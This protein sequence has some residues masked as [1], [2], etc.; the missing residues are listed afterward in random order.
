MS[1]NNYIQFRKFSFIE[2]ILFFLFLIPA[3]FSYFM[4]FK[5]G[6]IIIILLF[7]GKGSYDKGLREAIF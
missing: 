6:D 4:A 7:Y 1:S 3:V 5:I 2:W